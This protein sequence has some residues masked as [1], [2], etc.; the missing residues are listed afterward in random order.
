MKWET[1]KPAPLVAG[2]AYWYGN[3]AG[4]NV[5]VTSDQFTGKRVIL[6]FYPA[7]FTPVCTKEMCD[8]SDNLADLAKLDAQV[9]GISTDSLA[10]H[11]SFAHKH[12]L[13]FPLIADVDQRIGNLF[14]VAGKSPKS[15]HRRS[16]FIIDTDGRL[17]WYKKEMLNLFRTSAAEIKRVLAG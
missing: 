8:F 12:D 5:M 17:L 11:A 4:E 3:S 6:A 15:K 1:G 7:D 2:D 14:G 13:R 16:I 9:I 10:T